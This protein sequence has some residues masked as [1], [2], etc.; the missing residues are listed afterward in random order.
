MRRALGVAVALVASCG[1]APVASV[2][3]SAP[4][5]SCHAEETQSWESSLHHRAF[6]DADFRASFA[7][8][9]Q[10]F[11]VGCHAPLAKSKD[12]PRVADG[13]SC[14]AC[15]A[16]SRDAGDGRGLH[17]VGAA[18][19]CESCHDFQDPTGA[20][21]LQKTGAEHARSAF[22]DV[23]CASCH[24]PG[25]DHRFAASR[26]LALLRRAVELDVRAAGSTVEVIV[27]PQGVGH[28]F[29]TG[30]LFRRVRLVAYRE[31][32]EGRIV[33]TDERAFERTFE[34]GVGQRKER[35]DE[36]ISAETRFTL[37]LGMASAPTRAVVRLIYERGAGRVGEDLA[38][39]S[40]DVL[41]ERTLE[42]P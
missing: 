36:R 31:T 12:D 13:V 21:A 29:P 4:C 26:D 1:H 10:P 19:R 20:L 15:H 3:A 42:L 5:G 24:L 40:S 8:E 23:G 14:T 18:K 9:P 6:T 37:D 30:D 39:F 11:C 22:R 33:A 17:P 7:R 38:L 28:A 41:H 16:T 34:P 27:R 2:A 25:R 32:K 35:S